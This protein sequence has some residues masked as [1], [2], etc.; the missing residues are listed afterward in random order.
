MRDAEKVETVGPEELLFGL[1]VKVRGFDER[2]GLQLAEGEGIVR[3]EDDLVCTKHV[4]DQLEHLWVVCQ[5]VHEEAA[6]VRR[7]MHL[8]TERSIDGVGASVVA[9]RS[10]RADKGRRVSDHLNGAK[11]RVERLEEARSQ[12]GN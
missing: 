11:G 8:I 12:N 9:L 5:R 7:G 6:E 3:A 10:W 4:H 1:V 2:P